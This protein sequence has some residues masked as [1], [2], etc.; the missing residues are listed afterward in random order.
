MF[1]EWLDEYLVL[2]SELCVVPVLRYL[3]STEILWVGT[4]LILQMTL[5]LENEKWLPQ[6]LTVNQLWSFALRN[7]LCFIHYMG[8]PARSMSLE[9]EPGRNRKWKDVIQGENVGES[10]KKY[11]NKTDTPSQ[12]SVS[13]WHPIGLAVKEATRLPWLFSFFY[14][15]M[16]SDEAPSGGFTGHVWQLWFSLSAILT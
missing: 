11:R 2:T 1:V 15:S 5:W 8:H 16:L 12:C 10:Y 9:R 3:N 13:P 6:D 7:S 14:L 4:M